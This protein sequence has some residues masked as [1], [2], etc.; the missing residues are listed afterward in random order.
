LNGAK[1]VSKEVLYELSFCYYTAGNT[2]KAIEG[3][4]QLSNERD[5]MGQNSMYLLGDLYLKTGDKANARTAFQ[6]CAYN[7][8]NALQQRVSRFN[9]A[10]LSYE[11][12]Y[13]DIALTE[14]KGYLNAYPNSEYD[15]EG[16]EIL[17]QLLA[18]TSNFTD[19]IAVYQSLG[20]PTLAMQKI[21]PTILYG[22]AIEYLNDQQLINADELFAKIIADANAGKTAGYAN[23][24]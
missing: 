17:V 3:F 14:M 13:Q 5:S 11:L 21:Y 18:R 9:Y 4:K 16:K 19:A 24:W 10:K 15:V 2:Q 22:K 8:S 20:K 6:Y 23:F 12:G 1:K 7:S